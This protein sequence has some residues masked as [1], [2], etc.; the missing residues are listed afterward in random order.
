MNAILLLALLLQ[1]DE[2]GAVAAWRAGRF[3]AAL[4]HWR[5]AVRSSPD[6]G[7]D[8][9]W[10]AGVAALRLG[11]RAEAL[12]AFRRAA[13]RLPRDGA[14]RD[15]VHRLQR[16][17]GADPED[18]PTLGR[19]LAAAASLVTPAELLLLTATFET[20]SLVLL[21]LSKPRPRLRRPAFALLLVT[22]LLGARLLSVKFLPPPPAAIVLA[23]EAA[24]R[25]APDPAAAP[26]LRLHAGE[27]LTVTSVGPYWIEVRNRG[28]AGF[29]PRSAV[30][31]ID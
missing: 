28:G 19:A 24:L 13:L 3:E 11:R 2:A 26:L 17:L 29:V 6:P 12:H 9:L 4:E 31:L 8:L 10:N 23:P 18:L 20:L 16:D 14:I 1:S 30:G 15:V 27:S 7:G 21:V 22:L 5:A 25:A